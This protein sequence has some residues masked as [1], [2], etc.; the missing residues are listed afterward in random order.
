MKYLFIIIAI[1]TILI[2]NTNPI[3]AESISKGLSEQFTPIK[4]GYNAL[5]NNITGD[6]GYQTTHTTNVNRVSGNDNGFFAQPGEPNNVG[7]K[8]SITRAGGEESF[9]TTLSG[10][11]VQGVANQNNSNSKTGE[12]AQVSQFYKD[13][14]VEQ[15]KPKGLYNDIYNRKRGCDKKGQLECAINNLESAYAIPSYVIDENN[16]RS[17]NGALYG[18][19][20]PKTLIPPMISRPMYSLDWRNNSLVV[21]NIINGTSNENL[22][23]S[24]YLSKNDISSW[25]DEDRTKN[26]NLEQNNDGEIIENF[27]I[28]KNP[29]G[30]P[31]DYNNVVERYNIDN[32]DRRQYKEKDWSDMVNTSNGYN[33]GQFQTNQFPSNLPQGNCGQNEKLKEYNNRLFTTIVQPGTYYKQDIIEQVNSNA[34][35]SFQQQFLP[36]TIKEVGDGILI[37]DHDPE[38][39]PELPTIYQKTIPTIDNVYDPRFNGYGDHSRN[40]VDNVTGQPRFVYDDVNNVRMPNY[41]TRNQL[42]VFNFAD[43]VGITEPHGKSLNDIRGKAER[44][45]LD[46]SISHRDDM[47]VK[48]MRKTNASEWQRKQAPIRRNLR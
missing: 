46:D 37:E 38:N 31:R 32:P 19:Q 11:N 13:S 25:D 18:G 6:G 20:N 12:Y 8:C 44:A 34:G 22:Y 26:V 9:S 23:L 43:T 21:P 1:F 39:A 48:L 30:N 28:T 33:Q 5:V 24:G 42:D 16:R 4:E 2:L 7:G 27:N 15:T 36:R 17:D 45:F 3:V 41:I 10:S 29:R 14:S 47:T 40:Y 35:I